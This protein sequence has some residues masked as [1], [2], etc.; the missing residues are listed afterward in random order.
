MTQQERDDIIGA[1][2]L[3]KKLKEKE[4]YVSKRYKYYEQKYFAAPFPT[5]VPEKFR[6]LVRVLGWATL[7]V[8][9]LADSLI[10]ER[11]SGRNGSDPLMF[12]QIFGYNEREVLTDSLVLSALI[13][14]CSFAYISAD[15]DGY[16]TIQAIDGSKA[17]GT[18]DP[19]TRLLKE[20]YAVLE[21]ND[22]EKPTLYAYFAPDHTAY[23]D[24]S[25]R[26]IDR[27]ANSTGIPLLVPVCFMPSDAK[28]FG[29]SRITESSMQIMRDTALTL[30]RKHCAAEF[31]SFPQKYVAGMD[32]ETEFD[33]AVAT[34]TSFLKLTSSDNGEKPSFGQFQQGTMTPYIDDLK[35]SASMFAGENDMTLDDLGFSTDNP[36]TRESIE[37]A[38]EKLRKRARKAQR[39]IGSGLK[40]TAYLAACLR[41]GKRY[42]R[43]VLADIN[44]VWAPVFEPSPSALS[45][46]GDAVMKVQQSFPDYFTEEKLHIMTGL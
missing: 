5:I 11:F 13:S 33:E 12:D 35:S 37:A 6:S 43:Q 45:G 24:E 38:H 46:I 27:R 3:A 10:F 4:P 2:K 40:N 17:T 15:A 44:C 9:M 1:E 32:P 21:R 18:I 30:M 28:P 25:G 34:F 14:S 23:F 39:S 41:D 20:G 31:Y 29:H 42:G 22:L 36:A 26:V 7:S 16:P 19:R 8:D